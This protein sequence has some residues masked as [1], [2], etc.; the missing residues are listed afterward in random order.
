MVE[1]GAAL[2]VS[3]VLLRTT[4]VPSMFALTV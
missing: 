2:P 4:V 3:P 1:A